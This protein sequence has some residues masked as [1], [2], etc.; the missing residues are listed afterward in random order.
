M[1]ESLTPERK[2]RRESIKG[3]VRFTIA[4][5]FDIELVEDIVAAAPS[6]QVLTI[7]ILEGTVFDLSLLSELKD[8]LLL[9][10][11]E[12]PFLQQITL[13]GV[14]EFEFL[15]GVEINVNPDTTIEELDLAPLAGHPELHSVT[16][17]CPVKKLKGLDVLTS[18]SNFGSLGL[19]S[20]DNLELDLSILSG[21]KKLTSIYLG[22]MGPET[23]TQPYRITLPRNIPLKVFEIISC[24]SADVE[25]EIDFSI[26]QDLTSI[27][28]L[29]LTDCNL[30]S[31]DFDIL[32]PLERIG[33]I[34]LTENRISHLDI[35]PILEKPMF[36]ERALFRPPFVLD[37]NV[38]IQIDKKMEEEI[39]RI[40]KQP[41]TMIDDHEGEFAVNPEF[42]HQWLQKLL[43]AHTIEWI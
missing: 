9:K 22:D 38:I 42:G 34:N 32:K 35:S 27:D 5:S 4:D 8:L 10:I 37:A 24:Y 39:P 17:A 30:T 20:L 18:L 31:F 19:Y 12:G 28:S 15:T 25:L 2:L 1:D 3:L 26:M 36:T 21:C 14:Q 29:S 33:S 23:P 6:A 43:D 7:E 41:D 16:V 13:E 11:T 40:L